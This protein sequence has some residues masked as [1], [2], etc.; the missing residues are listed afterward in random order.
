MI[1]EFGY[2][3][4]F[5]DKG[6]WVSNSAPKPFEIRVN[7]TLVYSKLNP[8]NGEQSPKVSDEHFSYIVVMI[9]NVLTQGTSSPQGTSSAEPL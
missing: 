3:I 7:K 5:D 8:I 4:F 1:K 2:R 6:I 9:N